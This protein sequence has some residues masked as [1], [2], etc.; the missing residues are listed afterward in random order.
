MTSIDSDLGDIK[1]SNSIKNSIEFADSE[2]KKTSWLVDNLPI[3]VFRLSSK[4]SWGIDYIS[5]YVEKLTGYSKMD[6]INQKLSWFDII[7]SEDIPI[8]E[9][10]VQK[11]IKNKASYQVEYRIKK[12]DGTT[13]FIQEQSHPVNDESGSLAYID[14]MLLDINPHIKKREESQRV[15]VS[16]IP[17]PSLALYVD[18]SGKIKYINDYFVKMCKFR[19]A[20]E[21]VGLSPVELLGSGTK[22]SITEKVLKTGEAV[23]NLEWSLYLKALDKPIPSVISSVPIKDDSDV[24][25]GCLTIITDMTEIKE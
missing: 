8:R 5:N 3:T 19:S 7:F 23:Y 21:A 22:K 24:I 4:L 2:A 1:Y 6:F 10:V 17:E 14:G 16:N 9:K 12:A 18:T 20:D 15:I 13:A 11:A 25:I